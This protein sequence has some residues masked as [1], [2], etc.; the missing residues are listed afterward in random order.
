MNVC[1][2]CDWYHGDSSIDVITDIEWPV[3]KFMSHLSFFEQQ[4]E[5]TNMIISM[6]ETLVLDY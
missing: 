3:P 6:T 4:N 1:G 2:E 5:H